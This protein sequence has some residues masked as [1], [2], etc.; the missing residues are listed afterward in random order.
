[1]TR[2]R[3][4]IQAEHSAQR[5]SVRQSKGY[6]PVWERPGKARPHPEESDPNPGR[7]HPTTRRFPP[8]CSPPEEGADSLGSMCP[9]SINDAARSRPVC[10]ARI[11]LPHGQGVAL[12]DRPDAQGC[13]TLSWMTA[14]MP[15]DAQSDSTLSR[16]VVGLPY[17]I[18]LS[19][20]TLCP[21]AVPS[22]SVLAVWAVG[23][24][25]CLRSPLIAVRLG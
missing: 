25:G 16:P 18:H 21:L 12:D 11:A 6:P 9:L 13:P 20:G 8:G 2:A 19:G 5:R 14:P 24:L 22:C 7:T 10:A 17:L 15:R 1:M 4:A 23:C 3:A